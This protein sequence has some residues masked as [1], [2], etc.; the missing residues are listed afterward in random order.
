L[1]PSGGW[2]RAGRASKGPP[3][4]VPGFLPSHPGPSCVA[5][6]GGGSL[7]EGEVRNVS[8]NQIRTSSVEEVPAPGSRGG[9]TSGVAAPGPRTRETAAEAEA[10]LQTGVAVEAEAGEARS[11]TPVRE[12]KGVKRKWRE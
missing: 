12:G 1:A 11:P 6:A 4:E 2:P 3:L 10:A 7:R 5:G 9:K 8:E